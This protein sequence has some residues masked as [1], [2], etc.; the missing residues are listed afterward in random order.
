MSRLIKQELFSFN[1]LRCSKLTKVFHT[2]NESVLITRAV[3]YY[4]LPRPAPS[5]HAEFWAWCARRHPPGGASC[6]SGNGLH[7]IK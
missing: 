3:H 6:A 1:S 4:F 7:Q 5:G 2:V